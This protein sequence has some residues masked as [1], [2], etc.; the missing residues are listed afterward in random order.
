[1]LSQTASGLLKRIK[2]NLIFL[3][4]ISIMLIRFYYVIDINDPEQIYVGSTKFNLQE[5]LNM[6]WKA[7]VREK[8]ISMLSHYMKNKQKTDFEIFLFDERD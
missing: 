4:F 3:H 8:R 6:H 2:L 5:R 1:M 7:R